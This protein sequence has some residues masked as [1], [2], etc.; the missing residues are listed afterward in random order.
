MHTTYPDVKQRPRTEKVS[1]PLLPDESDHG[2]YIPSSPTLQMQVLSEASDTDGGMD[3]VNEAIS[4]QIR[5][6]VESARPTAA[7]EI[8]QLLRLAEFGPEKKS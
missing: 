5:I 1:P 8:E 6:S 4:N 2:D 7:G 3:L